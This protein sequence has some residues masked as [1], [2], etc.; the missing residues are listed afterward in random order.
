MIE[1]TSHRQGAILNHHHGTESARSLKITVQGISGSGHPVKVNGSPARMDGRNFSAEIELTQKINPVTA[2]VMTPYGVYSQELKLMWDKQSFR[3]YHCYIDDH[4]FV[5]TELARQR[6]KYAFD[7][8]YLAGLKKI[9]DETGFKVTLNSFYRNDH[10]KDG[11]LL[12]E[13]PDVWKSEFE[14][15]S[16][17]LK[18]SFHSYSEFPDRPYLESSAEEFGHDFDLVKN[19][20]IRF[21][22]ENAFTPPVVIHWGSIHPAAAAE[23]IRRGT[24]CYNYTFRPKVSG[25]PSLAER[26]NGGDMDRVQK[27]SLSGEDKAAS[28]EG[29]KMHYERPEELDYLKQYSAYYD[30][31][32]ELIFIYGCGICCNLVPLA[33]IPK[34]FEAA[35]RTAERNGI[36]TL[37]FASHEQ[38]TFPSYPNYLPDHMERIAL[39]ARLFAENGFEPVYFNDGLLGN[40][41]WERDGN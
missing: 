25:G 14:E 27:R 20:I 33:E 19:E 41:A 30:P 13:M 32:L 40:T 1:I 3:R 17:W 7:H 18:F 21:A 31:S 15:N 39:T 35:L 16:D 37:K 29:L 22:G 38:Y 23:L 28:T 26:M 8:F 24:H 12:K 6:P 9:H 34:R 4:S 5:F 10:D 36:E 2:S 11:F